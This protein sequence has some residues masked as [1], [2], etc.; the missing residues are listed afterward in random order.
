MQ[1]VQTDFSD[2]E[3]PTDAEEEIF[4]EVVIC[5][6]SRNRLARLRDASAWVAL[7]VFGAGTWLIFHLWIL[8]VAGALLGAWC[9]RQVVWSCLRLQNERLG[10]RVLELR[11]APTADSLVRKMNSG[12]RA[13]AI[14]TWSGTIQNL[15][16]MRVQILDS[17]SQTNHRLAHQF[18][19]ESGPLST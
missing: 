5:L 1:L 13:Y 10:A 7:G 19:S 15:Y 8:A 4:Q 18:L 2:V 16:V 6:A 11:Q 12:T 9:T 3:E 14:G 17:L